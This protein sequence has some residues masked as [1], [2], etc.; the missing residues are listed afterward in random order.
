[1]RLIFLSAQIM[2]VYQFEISSPLMKEK[3]HP[4]KFKLIHYLVRHRLAKA[5]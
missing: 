4:K 3:K 1:M 5:V 2:V